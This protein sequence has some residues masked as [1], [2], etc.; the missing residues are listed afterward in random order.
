MTDRIAYAEPPS[1]EVRALALR[2]IAERHAIDPIA[3]SLL[4]ALADPH[5]TSWEAADKATQA[6]EEHEQIVLDR[7]FALH[8]DLSA[9]YHRS[10]TP[11][12]DALHHLHVLANGRHHLEVLDAALKLQRQA[13]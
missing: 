13:M 2:I 10:V 9:D 7:L 12:P 11:D 5:G 8:P 1:P 3:R 6:Q 4:A